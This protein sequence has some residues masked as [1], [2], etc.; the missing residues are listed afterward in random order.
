VSAFESATKALGWTGKVMAMKNSAPAAA[1]EQAVAQKPDYIAISGIPAAAVKAALQKAHAAK[2]PVI[3]AATPEEPSADGWAAQ[4]GGTLVPDAENVGKWMV[5]DSGGKAN[6]VAVTIPQFPVLVGETDYFKN[7]FTKECSGCSY[8]ELAVTIDDVGAGAVPQKL[9]GYLQAHPDVNYVFF[10]FS[11]LGK[12]IGPALA[13]SG[14]DKVKLTGCCGD[15]AISQEILKGD[16]NAWTIAPNEYSA[17]TMVDAMTRLATGD[18]ITPDYEDKIY[19]S[20]SWVVDS[21]EAV[22]KYLKATNYD[23]YG[24]AGFEDQYQKLWN[25]S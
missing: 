1:M 7:D 19:G 8:D 15:A 22:N 18:G 24:P 14:L 10:T 11:D 13:R 6:V 12:G 16:T 3:S 17:Y 23:W 20:P 9:T 21:P 4:V 2:I 25:G 5:K